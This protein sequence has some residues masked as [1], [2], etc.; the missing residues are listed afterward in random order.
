MGSRWLV[1]QHRHEGSQLINL[2]VFG[3]CLLHL[4]RYLF[5]F[6]KAANGLH[7]SPRRPPRPPIVKQVQRRRDIPITLMV[8]Q[9]HI[10]KSTS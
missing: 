5:F 9:L 8:D 2:A 3:K 1:R 6:L 10:G 4:N 7:T